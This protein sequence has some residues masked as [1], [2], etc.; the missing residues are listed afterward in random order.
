MSIGIPRNSSIFRYVCHIGTTHLRTPCLLITIRRGVGTQTALT[1]LLNIP[2]R[3]LPSLPA[4]VSKY[5][6]H[7]LIPNSAAFDSLP[8]HLTLFFMC[9]KPNAHDN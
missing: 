9:V 8:S 6:C 5:D 3:L 4:R 2:K 7:A 1:F